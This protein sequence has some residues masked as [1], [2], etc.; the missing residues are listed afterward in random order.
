MEAA[1]TMADVY[2]NAYITLGAAHASDA[3]QGL[4]SKPD[5]P[6]KI[7]PKFGLF[8]RG[9]SQP[10][11]DGGLRPTL[12]LLEVLFWTRYIIIKYVGLMQSTKYRAQIPNEVLVG[13][14]ASR[15][16]TTGLLRVLMTKRN[17]YLGRA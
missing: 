9:L 14:T 4:Y 3:T 16:H 17:D 12:P 11:G 15:V 6:V 2:E 5:S 1:Y 8:V 7:V 13:A 10:Y